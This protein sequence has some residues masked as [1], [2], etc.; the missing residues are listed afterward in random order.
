MRFYNVA[1][2]QFVVKFQHGEL[3][4]SGPLLSPTVGYP[5]VGDS[6]ESAQQP[7]VYFNTQP[8]TQPTQF[9]DFQLNE[10]SSSNQSTVAPLI[11]PLSSLMNQRHAL[12]LHQQLQLVEQSRLSPLPSVSEQGTS[13]ARSSRTGSANVINFSP[14]KTRLEKKTRERSTDTR[15][16]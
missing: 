5:M 1:W 15:K 11:F 2:L 16:N 9:S 8:A 7:T 3:L 4:I 12:Q 14:Y 13:D 10:A 6:E